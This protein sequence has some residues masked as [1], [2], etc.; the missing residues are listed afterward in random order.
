VQGRSRGFTPGLSSG[1]GKSAPGK[2][3]YPQQRFLLAWLIERAE[4]MA[5]GTPTDQL[6]L[7]NKGIPWDTNAFAAAAGVPATSGSRS[8]KRLEQRGLVVCTASGT[9]P[10]RRVQFIF[11]TPEG[12]YQGQRQLYRAAYHQKKARILAAHVPL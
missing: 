9:P 2:G 10:N 7:R 4:A 8:L 5:V 6:T 1:R 12:K 3:L 11:L